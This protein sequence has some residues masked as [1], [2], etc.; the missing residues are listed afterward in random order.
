MS[1]KTNV[2]LRASEYTL[3][4]DW[5][6]MFID[7][8]KNIFPDNMI[9][10]ETTHTLQYNNEDHKLSKKSKELYRQMIDLVCQFESTREDTSDLEWKDLDKKT[11]EHAVRNYVVSNYDTDRKKIYNIIKVALHVKSI[12]NADIDYK[13]G[14]IIKIHNFKYRDGSVVLPHIPSIPIRTSKIIAKKSSIH[15]QMNKWTKSVKQNYT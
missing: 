14:C 15:K 3:D 10:D 8:S 2:F 13:D 5:K 11:K 4:E 12:T 7:C 6:Q 1:N 9:Y